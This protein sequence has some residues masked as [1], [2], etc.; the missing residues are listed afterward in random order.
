MLKNANSSFGELKLTRLFY[1]GYIIYLYFDVGQNSNYQILSQAKNIEH[2]SAEYNL[3]LLNIIVFCG[4]Q[5]HLLCEMQDTLSTQK[6]KQIGPTPCVKINDIP[7]KELF[8]IVSVKQHDIPCFC[9][10]TVYLL[11]S[12]LSNNPLPFPMSQ[13]VQVI[14]KVKFNNQ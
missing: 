3:D 8:V 2:S 5:N 11:L 4:K 14:G 6:V 9:V 1:S 13:S 7:E 12:C 10:I